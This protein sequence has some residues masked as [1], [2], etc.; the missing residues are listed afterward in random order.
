M[1]RIPRPWKLQAFTRVA[2]LADRK[3]QLEHG[4]GHRQIGQ[5]RLRCES[6]AVERLTWGPKEQQLAAA[7]LGDQAAW[8]LRVARDVGS[9]Q[10]EAERGLFGCGM[11]A[12]REFVAIQLAREAWH[13]ASLALGGEEVQLAT[14][15]HRVR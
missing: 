4:H 13:L 3:P 5:G 1:A 7:V 6:L 12:E 15:G 8:L 11:D 10:T 2:I 14:L 9:V